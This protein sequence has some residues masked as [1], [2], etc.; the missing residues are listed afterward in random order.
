MS[1]ASTSRLYALEQ[2]VGRLGQYKSIVT[3]D[4]FDPERGSKLD[5]NSEIT[6]SD[7]DSNELL[8]RYSI[9]GIFI[10][11]NNKSAFIIDKQEKKEKQNGKMNIYR[12]INPGDSL[13]GWQVENI[14][15][16]GVKVTLGNKK[17]LI[18]V[19][20]N[21][22][23]ERKANAPVAMQTPQPK[24]FPPPSTASPSARRIN[25]SAE[26]EKDDKTPRRGRKNKVSRENS[27]ST[28]SDNNIDNRQRGV[29]RGKSPFTGSIGGPKIVPSAQNSNTSPESQSDSSGNNLFLQLLRGGGR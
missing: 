29:N 26:M 22:K 11:D 24:V 2:D 20:D 13:D 9:Y 7:T 27:R 12:R 28:N 23:G 6:V 14:T 1:L 8:E 19:F 17:V 18:P 15:S 16:K 10:T 21:S 5:E 3:K 4:I 25:H